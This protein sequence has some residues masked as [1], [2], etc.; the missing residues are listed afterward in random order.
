MIRVLVVDDSAFMRRLLVKLLEPHEDI[1]VVATAMDG[2][3]ALDKIQKLESSRPDVVTLDLE[4][5]RL[6]GMG[7]LRR[8]VDEFQLPVILVSAHTSEGATATFEGLAAGAVDFVTKPDRIFSSPMGSLASELV[9]KI[10]VAAKTKPRP[11][12]AAEPTRK[13]RRASSSSWT[14]AGGAPGAQAGRDI[15]GIAIST[16]GPNA[17]SQLMAQIRGDFS[18]SL[19]IVQ[20]MPEGFTEQFATRLAK[21]SAIDVHEAR[22][23]EVVSPS[24]AFVAP[25]GQHMELVRESGKLRLRLTLAEPVNG[26]R[27]SAAVLFRS[28]AKV[29]GPKCVGVVMTGMGEDGADGASAIHE[30]GGYN[31]AQDEASSVVFGMPKAAI[32]RGV[33]DKVLPFVQNIEL[34]EFALVAAKGEASWKTSGFSS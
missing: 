4:M 20:H 17:L 3:F 19:L 11:R 18:P 24:C 26:H 34:L 25:G 22:E 31:L 28:M 8:I 2:V 7:T 14:L 12:R 27:P 1:D 30:T 15:V 23:G 13:I 9:A 6:D 33:V 32:E 10:R 21:L 16:G 5:P 29:V